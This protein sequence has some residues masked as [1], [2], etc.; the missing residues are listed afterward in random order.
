MTN[1]YLK[2]PLSDNV[3]NIQLFNILNKLLVSTKANY[4]KYPDL[5]FSKWALKLRK[6]LDNYFDVY[7]KTVK[8]TLH[9]KGLYVDIEN[10]ISD[11]L[12]F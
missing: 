2:D 11:Y 5:Y 7:I 4:T 9:D 10:I 3:D 8:R 1:L 12:E 6:M